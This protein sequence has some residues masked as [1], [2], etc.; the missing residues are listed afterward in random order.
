MVIRRLDHEI[1]T[2]RA[3]RFRNIRNTALERPLDIIGEREKRVAPER[4]A[5]NRFEVRRFLFA[6]EG[7]GT[8]GEILLPHIVAQYVLVVVG[9]VN[10]DNV[11]LFGS[12]YAL[13]EL[14]I[15]HLFVLAK[16]PQIRL[17]RGKTGAVVRA[18]IQSTSIPAFKHS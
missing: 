9:E 10:I 2:H 3:A 12:P 4:N 16:V 6:R 5:R 7:C 13:R 8:D 14:Q 17:L 11:V 15:Q 1:V 18:P